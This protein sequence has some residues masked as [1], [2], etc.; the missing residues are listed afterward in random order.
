MAFPENQRQKKVFGDALGFLSHMTPPL[1]LFIVMAIK[2]VQ[3]LFFS[4]T[5][6][7]HPI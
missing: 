7:Y 1:S 4:F 6:V 5:N 3:R 2:T